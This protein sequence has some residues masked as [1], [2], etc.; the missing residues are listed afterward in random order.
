MLDDL[1]PTRWRRCRLS[2]LLALLI[3]LTLEVVPE[4]SCSSLAAA[5]GGGFARTPLF[6]RNYVK[7]EEWAKANS[8][9]SKWIRPREEFQ[10]EN[11]KFKL[12]LTV[13]S[14]KAFLNGVQIWLS[15]PVALH[16]LGAYIAEVDLQTLIHPIL[17]PQRREHAAKTIVLDPGHGGK[18]R[19]KLAGIHEE[20][21]HT[22]ALAKTLKPLLENMGYTVAMTRV[23]DTTLVLED[24]PEIAR[25]KGGD[26]LVSLHFNSAGDGG[27]GVRG[28]EVYCMTPAGESS[29]NGTQDPAERNF[30]PG[31]RFDLQNAALGYHVH[32]ALTRRLGLE[33]RGLRHAR[34]AVLKMAHM[35][36][37]LI[38]GGFIS[39]A[40]ELKLIANP[41]YRR[42]LA[43][44][45]AAG[46][47][48]YIKLTNPA[49]RKGSK[50]SG[51]KSSKGGGRK[52]S[53][54][55]PKP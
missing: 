16:Q 25:Q 44:S 15:A 8:A 6:G 3:L 32:R 10:M 33:D 13:D 23:E 42:K 20:K 53:T 51:D 49:E 21:T 4:H 14:Q 55:Q 28:I 7:A 52:G 54:T 5:Q 18:D 40:Q 22:L 36:S 26:L 27:S 41:S 48:R 12:L 38:E 45:I 9:A 46:V 11:E 24:R 35:P 19:G 2:K 1:S 34:F 31:N 37:I 30:S 17:F 29:T 43:E 47:D 39:N 50:P